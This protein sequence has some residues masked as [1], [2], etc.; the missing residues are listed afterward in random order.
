MGPTLTQEDLIFTDH[1]CRDPISDKVSLTGS[2]VDVF[3][4]RSPIWYQVGTARMLTSSRSQDRY[5]L[6]CRAGWA[7]GGRCNVCGSLTFLNLYS[8]PEPE[9]LPQQHVFQRPECGLTGLANP[10]HPA[11]GETS[12]T[13]SLD[14]CFV[15]PVRGGKS[16]RGPSPASQIPFQ[17]DHE[18]AV[19]KRTV[20]FLEN[21]AALSDSH[22]RAASASPRLRNAFVTRKATPGSLSS[23]FLLRPPPAFGNHPLSVAMDSPIPEI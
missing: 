8:L 15:V 6:Y 22:W 16:V 17:G 20:S 21:S 13:F 19:R 14:C 9:A 2:G 23:G 3:G 1:V 7:R 10:V 11:S 18:T 4:G 5:A 12:R